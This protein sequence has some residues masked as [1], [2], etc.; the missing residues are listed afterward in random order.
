MAKLVGLLLVL[1][2]LA[3]TVALVP[4][5]GRTVLDRWR[6]APS[7]AVFATRA[8]GEVA[9]ASGLADPSARKA[10]KAGAGHER[11]AASHRAPPVERHT[12]ADREALERIVAEHAQK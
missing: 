9:V 12:A 2:A 10:G 11:A 5:G 1:G 7:A 4:V 6:K 3:A 8:W